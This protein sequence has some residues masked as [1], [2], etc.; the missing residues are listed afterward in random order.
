VNAVTRP[1][2]VPGP[3]AGP[4]PGAPDVPMLESLPHHDFLELAAGATAPREARRRI[5]KLLPEWS[6]GNYETVT[7]LIASELISNAVTATG[8]VCWHGTPPPVLVWL[9]AGPG[10]VAVL[11]W[12]VTVVPPVPRDAASTDESGRGLA[13]VAALSAGNGYYYPQ[14]YA[15]KVSWAIITTP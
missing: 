11:A 1:P 6:L 15:G 13:I 3:L 9:R 14:D 2:D 5:G 8:A 10:A 4:A 7:S 12:D